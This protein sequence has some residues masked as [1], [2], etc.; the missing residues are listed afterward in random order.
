MTPARVALAGISILALVGGMSIL[1]GDHAAA[2]PPVT[3]WLT[4]PDRSHLL[5]AQPAAALEP[6]DPG[7]PTIHVDAARSY[8]VMEGFGTSLTE[9][10]ASVIT[11]SPHRDTI[12]RDLFDRTS[13][14]G[15][16]YLRQPMGASDFVVGSHF[17]YND[18]PIGQTD[19]GLNRFSIDR[20]RAEI[21]PL[22]RQ[23]RQL[24][25]E[26]K[27]LGTP[28]SPP[29]WMKTS[30]S[31][32]G[33]QLVDDDR[34][35]QAYAQYFVR[36]VQ[37][38]AAAGVP[39]HALSVQ[40]EP[41]N[42]RPKGYPGADVRPQHAT[43]LIKTL[44]AA[45]QEAGLDTRILAFDHNWAL[46]PDDQTPI[47]PPDP[48]YARTVLADAEARKF[49]AGVAYHCYYGDPSAQSRLHESYPDLGIH[50]TECSG[51]RST[52]PANTFRDTL[53]WQTRNLVIG[54]VRHWARTVIGW[55]AALNAA[56]GPHNG[57]CDVCTGV[58][59]V[60]GGTVTRNAEYYVFGH[61]SKFVRPGAVRVE[62]NLVGPLGNVAF[63][64]PDGTTVLVVLNDSDGGEARF[65]VRNG[66]QAYTARLP[67]GAVATFVQAATGVTGRD[68]YDRLEAEDYDDQYGT[69]TEA[70]SDSGGGRNVGW[71][72]AGDWLAYSSVDFGPTG[73]TGPAGAVGVRLRVASGSAATGIV[74][75]RLDSHTA[76]PLASFPVANTGGWQSWVTAQRTHRR[77]TGRHTVYLTARSASAEDIVNVNWLTFVPG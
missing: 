7:L 56:G 67:A 54:S 26:V 41:Q 61:A 27:V 43:R 21:I 62:S 70:T 47:D 25:P 28:W 74:D 71:T 73:G 16:S 53:R 8:Q 9:S 1:A 4:T 15:M 60:D 57:G 42:R 65:T 75:V 49:I 51:I 48:D 19:Y 72:A 55:N 29:A 63:R 3:M 32:I 59:T 5:A 76:P 23:A 35:Y 40:N 14:I 30:R 37:S 77:V 18:M 31:L 64:N 52:V 69:Q 44:G 38:Y 11:A 66:N 45:L 36:F 68:A 13:G 22:L 24:N 39:V 33:G 17:T 6:P 34:V 46:H 58:L 20:D 12:M 10:A 50:F 2:A